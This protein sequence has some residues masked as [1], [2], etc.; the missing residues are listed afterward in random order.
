M[1]N[2]GVLEIVQFNSLNSKMRELS[3][4]GKTT[5]TLIMVCTLGVRGCVKHWGHIVFSDF[6]TFV[7]RGGTAP[8]ASE[9]AL[10]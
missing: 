2:G 8:R 3:L 9:W 7:T 4:G 5:A 1:R 6:F 10:V